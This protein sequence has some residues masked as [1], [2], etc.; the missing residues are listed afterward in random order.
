MKRLKNITILLCFLSLLAFISCSAEDKTG[1][2]NNPPEDTEI[3]D[4]E[5]GSGG[6]GSSSGGSSETE[7]GGGGTETP[8]TEP[9][10]PPSDGIEE[11]DFPPPAG[12]YRSDARRW[13][14]GVSGSYFEPEVSIIDGKTKIGGDLILHGSNIE[15][16]NGKYESRNAKFNVSKWR[17]TTKD[18]KITKTEAVEIEPY[19]IIG[20][21]KPETPT[22]TE[23]I[24]DYETK[25]LSITCKVT[26]DGIE[27]T[28]STKSEKY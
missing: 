7:E 2:A 1:V 25:T 14:A 5:T 18:G 13:E 28:L 17:K 22:F 27:K 26:I 9:E 12:K 20:N 21:G 3:T 15:N 24:Y 8:P 10:T 11:G 4:G 23:V 6:T 16:V 19:K